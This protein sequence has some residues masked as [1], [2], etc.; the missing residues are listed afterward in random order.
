MAVTNRLVSPPKLPVTPAAPTAEPLRPK[1]AME[2]GEYMEETS[3]RGTGPGV[4]TGA[5]ELMRLGAA[6]SSRQSVAVFMCKL[7]IDEKGRW[8][9]NG[10]QIKRGALTYRH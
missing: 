5:E 9:C 1:K 4:D 2:A 8:G 10:R 7:P 6:D 3:G